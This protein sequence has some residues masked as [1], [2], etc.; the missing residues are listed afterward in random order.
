M[1][2]EHPVCRPV[3]TRKSGTVNEVR[4]SMGARR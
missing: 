2:L 4:A 1:F 3:A